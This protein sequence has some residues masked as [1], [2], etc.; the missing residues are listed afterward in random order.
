MGRRHDGQVVIKT[1]PQRAKASAVVVEYVQREIFD[2]RLR[3][4]DRVHVE[5][6]AEALD[7]SPTPVRE[8][9]V[10][11]ERD[12]LVTAQ[13]H[14]ATFVQH[15]DARSLRADFHVLGLLGGV[16]AA[17]VAMDGNPEVVHRLEHLLGELADSGDSHARR[18]D[19]A[20]EILDVQHQ[21]G[22]TP[23][24]L[25]ELQG[26]GG[27][28]GWAVEHSDRRPHG[29]VVEAHRRVIAAIA[30][31][32]PRAAAQALLREAKNAAEQVVHELIRRGVLR[33]DGTNAAVDDGAIDGSETRTHGRHR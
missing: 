28:L 22:A 2:G 8:A 29:E 32:D 24:L 10:L 7:V 3:C 21:A 18:K 30:A 16:A 15:F 19:V 27:F 14:R 11:L 20:T 33:G 23:R 5:R 13:V 17:R 6:L 31:G 9:L 1:G 25:A 26:H 12:G 4:G